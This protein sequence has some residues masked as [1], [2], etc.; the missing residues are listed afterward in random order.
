MPVLGFGYVWSTYETVRDRLGCPVESEKS[1][2]SAEETFVGG[3]MFW[4]QDL[5]LIYAVYG[6]GTWQSFADT[7]DNSQIEEDPTIVPPS[8]FY[9][10]KRGF[11]KVWRE[12]S[13]VRDKL[14]WATAP[15]RGFAASWQAFEGGM[16]LW[17]D[18]QGTVVLYNDGTW[19]HH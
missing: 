9:Q 4:R 16:M 1:T 6:D 11:G 13:G 10:P 5:L 15:E 14:S 2:W 3:Y 12:Q 8:G 18:H 17:S 7:W 19:S